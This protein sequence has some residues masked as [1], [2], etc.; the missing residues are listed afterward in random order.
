MA[1]VVAERDRLAASERTPPMVLTI[2]YCAPPSASGRQPMPAFW[3]RPK[4]L[5]LGSCRSISAVRGSRPSGPSPS[6]RDEAIVS[7]E[8]STCSIGIMASVRASG[9]CVFRAAGRQSPSMKLCRFTIAPGPDV[10]IGLL[11]N[12]DSIIDLSSAGVERMHG[13]I[14]RADL[15]EQLERFAERRPPGA[16][17]AQR[18][19]PDAGRT[20]GGLGRRRD[21]SPQQTG[22]HGG[23]RVQRQRLRPRLRRAAPGDLLQV[24]PGQGR[25]LPEM[26]L[27]SG[28]TLAGTFPSPSW[29]W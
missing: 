12:G 13:L 29:R 15:R 20:P 24:A 18:P 3:V 27:A 8:P 19:A 26:R 1:R 4:M 6:T 22:A 2:T 5:P 25:R 10:R 11:A 14:E 23:V 21:L 17:A 28:G 16:S 9:H 7:A